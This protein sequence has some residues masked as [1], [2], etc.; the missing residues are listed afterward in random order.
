[1]FPRG[2]SRKT[3]NDGRAMNFFHNLSL[4]EEYNWTYNAV[5]ILYSE[6]VRTG[7]HHNSNSIHNILTLSGP[8]N[9]RGEGVLFE[10]YFLSNI[11]LFFLFFIF[12]NNLMK[13][14]VHNVIK[15]MHIMKNTISVRSFLSHE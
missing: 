7:T 13:A 9:S 10:W 5:A 6:R 15:C 8:M 14:L 4:R 12:T 3:I 2:I 11:E 1:M